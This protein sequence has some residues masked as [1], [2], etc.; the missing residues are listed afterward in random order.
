MYN[1]FININ[2]SNNLTNIKHN[3]NT[4]S[5]DNYNNKYNCKNNCKNNC[6]LI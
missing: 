1:P 6:K 2:K 5:N 3:K 4:I